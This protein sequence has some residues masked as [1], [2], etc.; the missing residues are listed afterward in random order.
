MTEG[1]IDDEM[2]EIGDPNEEPVAAEPPPKVVIEYRER[3][4]PWML[5]PPLLI[6]SAVGAVMGYHKLT[7]DMIPH[8][9]VTVST[10]P[11]VDIAAEL[12][13]PELPRTLD[14]PEA[15]PTEVPSVPIDK[16]P[17]PVIL[18]PVA[19]AEVV[20]PPVP[21][22]ELPPAPE[23]PAEP[24]KFPTATGVGFDPKA[25]EADRKGEPPPAD[26][27]LTPVARQD[28]P[29][30]PARVA[31]PDEKNL[32][33]EVDPD[34]LPPDPRLA[35]VRQQ[36]RVVEAGKQVEADRVRFHNELREICRIARD[37]YIKEVIE[38][39]TRY[40]MQVDPKIKKLAGQLFGQSGRYA[41]SDRQ[42]RIDVLRA[43]GYPETLVLEDI[44]TTYEKGRI[45]ERNGPRN[46][47]DAMHRSILFLLR[48][49]PGQRAAN[50]KAVVRPPQPPVPAPPA[51]AF[52]GNSG[53]R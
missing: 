39:S 50:A 20:L 22:V 1:R 10:V 42:T 26:P 32:P 51:P 28:P 30:E 31:V 16:L 3:G 12:K 13:I 48:Y 33:R 18:P 6:I 53:A 36:E 38:L 14:G 5:I 43:I 9:V 45:G 11:P 4:V 47:S 29:R 34:L 24:S 2:I 15:R 46:V 49:A 7:Q 40:G 37:D 21:L 44:F 41:G 52:L 23:K 8:R 27:A 35:K 25:L 19:T 17:D